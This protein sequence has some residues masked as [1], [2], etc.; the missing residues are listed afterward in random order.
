MAKEQM[1]PLNAVSSLP[2]SREEIAQFVLARRE[3]VQAIARR[4]LTYSAR[5]VFDSDDVIASVMRRIDHL[6]SKGALRIRSEAELWALIATIA[7]NNAVSKT[8]LMARART[9]LSEDLAFAQ[10][11]LNCVTPCATDDDAENLVLELASSIS[12]P[13]MRQ[14]FLLRVRGA[15]HSAV[16]GVLGISEAAF[17]QRWSH[18]V[19]SLSERFGSRE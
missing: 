18:L 2:Q 19:R 17:R 13:V 9:L 16:A 1:D 8:R 5:A 14:G 3:R 4:K 7:G 10:I 11:M 12:D 6:A 15:S